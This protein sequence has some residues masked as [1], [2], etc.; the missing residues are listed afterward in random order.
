MALLAPMSELEAV[1]RMLKSIGQAPVNT[2]EVTGIG[3]VNKARQDLEETSRDVQTA[4]WSW[5]TDDAYP[6]SPDANGYILIPN[7]V[8]DVDAADPTVNVAQRRNP[9][10]G[11]MCLWD[12]DNRTFTFTSPVDCKIIWGIAFNDLPQIARTYISTAAARRFQARVVSSTVL[13]RYNETDEERAW[14]LLQRGERR[15]RD[16]NVFR[17]NAG[18][19]RFYSR[20]RF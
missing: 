18:V 9:Q 2:L 14:F 7:G 5:N 15:T 11:S 8:L 6:L 12:L 10:N 19:R 1:N 17:A 13:D 16:T 3:D 20:R 4:G